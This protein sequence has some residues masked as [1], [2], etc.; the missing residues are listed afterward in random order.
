MT[1]DVG[2]IGYGFMGTAHANAL[3]RL[4]MFFPETPQVNR[5]I[6][7]GREKK[8]LTDAADRLGFDR[9]T[10]DWEDAVES[11]DVLY[12]LAPTHLH[13]EPT[14]EA[15]AAGVHVLCEKPLARSLEGAERMV[16][17][18]RLSD[19]VAGCAY[20]YRYVPALQLAKQLVDKGALGELR[21]FRGQFLQDWQADEDGPWLW[22][23][24]DDVAGAGAVGDQGSHTIDLAQWL[25][26]DIADVSGRLATE[27]EERS[28]PESDER[29]AVTNDDIYTVHFSFQSGT[30]GMLEGSR[31]AVGHKNTNAVEL[32]GSNG[33]I[34]F[35]CERL[36]ELQV[37]FE[38]DYG[39]QTIN[40]TRDED[41]YMDAWWPA[42]HS[43]GWE[44]TVIHEN[45][46]FL[47]AV[48]GATS[49]EPSFKTAFQTQRVVD[50]IRR[51]D[52]TGKRVS[53]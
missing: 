35:D 25:V 36:N 42:G 6:I 18:A 51:S 23:N 50:A 5:S 41:P 33:A 34:Q 1:L 4:P 20:N 2:F 38:D 17:A 21:Y 30:Q 49:F 9:T 12:N 39:F 28:V 3:A 19:A 52:K 48:D 45:H 40:V 26:G 10:T 14:I 24:N 37:Q 53:L 46:E 27:I 7:V 43:I 32:I 47:R 44:H 8:A 29:R 11:V 22:R 31:I 13:P 16:E 15:L